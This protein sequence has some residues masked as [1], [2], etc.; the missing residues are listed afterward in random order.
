L[1]DLDFCL[2]DTCQSW[3]LLPDG[4]YERIQ[5]AAER[6]VSAQVE[7]LAKYAAGAVVSP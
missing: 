6:P 7:L 3:R 2:S 4:K 1:R 5:R